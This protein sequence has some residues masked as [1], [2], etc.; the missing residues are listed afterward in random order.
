MKGI[1]VKNCIRNFVCIAMLL[2]VLCMS[3][4]SSYITSFKNDNIACEDFPEGDD[5]SFEK[6]IDLYV[7]ECDNILSIIH[8]PAV[9][10]FDKNQDGFHSYYPDLHFPPPEA[11]V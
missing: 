3:V 9:K 4:S 11:L 1:L 8:V 6:L 2:Q 10:H 7:D 5:S